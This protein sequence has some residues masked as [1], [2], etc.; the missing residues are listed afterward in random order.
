[1]FSDVQPLTLRFPGFSITAPNLF[2]L[3]ALACTGLLA[4]GLYLQHVVGL[5]PCPMCIVQRYMMIG[6][7]VVCGLTALSR[8]RGVQVAGSGVALLFAGG[9]AFTAARQ[10][11]FFGHAVRFA[12]VTSTPVTTDNAQA[13]V[14]ASQAAL[15]YSPEPK[16]IGKLI[17]SARLTGNEALAQWHEAQQQKVYGA[18][19]D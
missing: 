11:W 13:M 8:S 7:G 12:E 9:G 18:K 10:S 16:V 17:Q 6:V 14:L 3:I 19:A 1:M 5:N 4:F 15:H 2:G